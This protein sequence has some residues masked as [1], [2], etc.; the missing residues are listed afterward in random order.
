[1]SPKTISAQATSQVGL[2]DVSTAASCFWTTSSPVSWL[3]VSSGGSGPG[4]VS[5]SLAANSTSVARSTNLVVAGQTIA[6]TQAATTPTPPPPP[7]NLKV[8]GGGGGD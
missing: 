4:T 5:Y 8:V 2:I 3:T 6:V 1:V 7:T